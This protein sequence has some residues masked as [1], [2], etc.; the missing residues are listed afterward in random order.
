MRELLT[1]QELAFLASQGLGPD[2]V[3]DARGYSQ[4]VWFGLI[5]QAGKT[6]AL[7]SPCRKR[8]HRL[9]SRKG[10]CI[11]CD[12]SK[13]AFAGRHD[14]EQY[15][16]IAGSMKAKL[17]KV[18]VCKELDQRL[19]QICFERH[20]DAGDWEVLYSIYHPR[21]GEVEHLTL[22]RLARYAVYEPYWKNGEIQTSTEMLRC[23]FSKALKTLNEVVGDCALFNPWKRQNTAGYEFGD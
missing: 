15:V 3:F 10:H 14:L 11:Q 7:G 18:G 17:L 20:G 23:S 6:V 2:D 16:Y 1:A 8:R 13:L 19:R 12:T 9:R 21:S 22:S 4:A 5:K